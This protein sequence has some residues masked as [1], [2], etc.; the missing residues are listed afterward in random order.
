MKRQAILVIGGA[1]FIGSH[2]VDALLRNDLQVTV[3]D[4][5]SSGRLDN[6][7]LRHPNLEFIEGDVLEYPLVVELVEKCDAVLHLAAIVSV[8]VT[9]AEPIYSFQVNVQG[10]LHVLEAVRV[11]KRSVRFV[12]ASSAAVYG[13][14]D[15]LPCQDE[16]A[17]TTEVISPY[18]MHKRNNEEYAELYRQLH[19]EKSLGLRYFNVYGSRQAPDSPYS[20]VI[21]RFVDAYKRNAPATVYGDGKQSRDFI[22]V[23]DV[24]R[25]NCM[26]L[27]S[28]FT[29]TLNIAT[30]KASTLLQL[31]D[32][33]ETAGTHPFERQFDQPRA[34]DILA[35][36]AAVNLAEQAINFRYQVNLPAGI[37]E[38]LARE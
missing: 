20:G 17:L 30:G 10:F 7:D 24:V 35:S 28:D 32:A 15:K 6:L 18:A 2:T 29:G 9:I 13:T 12:Y 14:T 19:G 8:P 33:I 36:Y 27:Q 37:K 34:G 4:N 31:M 5:L 23:S 25:A 3:L 22:H 26:A 38:M 1:G 11:V 16:I 21:S